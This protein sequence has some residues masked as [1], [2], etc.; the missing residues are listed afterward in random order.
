MIGSSSSS[1]ELSRIV[2]LRLYTWS[3]PNPGPNGPNIPNGLGGGVTSPSKSGCNTLPV[4]MEIFILC[5]PFFFRFPFLEF[6]LSFR[7]ESNHDDGSW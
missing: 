1:S 4:S 3:N 2:R 7:T 5:F 6:M